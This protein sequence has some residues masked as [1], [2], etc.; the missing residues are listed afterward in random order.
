M[1]SFENKRRAHNEKIRTREKKLND[2][3]M[4][5]AAS[6]INITAVKSINVPTLV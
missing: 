2:T 4:V 5:P 6:W 1:A 3:T